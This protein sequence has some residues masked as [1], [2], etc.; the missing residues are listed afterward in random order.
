[1]E[2]SSAWKTPTRPAAGSGSRC[3]AQG[4]PRATPF[5]RNARAA[6]ETI[7]LD[8]AY[9]CGEKG[10]NEQR[11]GTDRRWPAVAGIREHARVRTGRFRGNVGGALSRG[12]PGA[13]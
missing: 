8:G 1:M 5:Q 13:D 6:G 11:E 12:L 9:S 3:R 10:T 7:R 4:L 2:V